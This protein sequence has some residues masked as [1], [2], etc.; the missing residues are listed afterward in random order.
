MNKK[1]RVTFCDEISKVVG[2]VISRQDYTVEERKSSWWSAEEEASKNQS[3]NS[4]STQSIPQIQ[5]QEPPLI[6]T[7]SE[8][9]QQNQYLQ[10]QWR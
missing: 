3:H 2:T 7:V 9:S 10:F 8:H 6:F 4:N 1:C 5:I